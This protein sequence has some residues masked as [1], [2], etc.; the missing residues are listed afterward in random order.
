METLTFT[1]EDII[2]TMLALPTAGG[3]FSVEAD[4]QF[5]LADSTSRRWHCS[6]RAG[7]TP[8]AS[9][10]RTPV[11]P[12]AASSVQAMAEQCM[13]SRRTETFEETF[14]RRDGSTMHIGVTWV[15]DLENGD[16]PLL[17]FTCSD[18][19]E[20]VNVRMRHARELSLFASGF[21]QT[22]AWCGN[23]QADDG[24]ISAP[25][26]VETFGGPPTRIRCPDCER[27]HAKPGH[28]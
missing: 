12:N 8:S 17:V 24:W 2:A 3:V 11:Q 20:L 19:T 23:V 14:V 22:C 21:V 13:R 7:T 16:S 5:R 10:R 25:E 9:R 6:R 4:D 1:S 26:Y 15:P 28:P 18:I 27:A